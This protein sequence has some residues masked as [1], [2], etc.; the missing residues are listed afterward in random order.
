MNQKLTRRDFMSSAGWGLG[1]LCILSSARVARAYQAN[2]RL[3]LAVFGNMY[4]AQ[5]FLIAAHIYNAEVVAVCNPDQRKISDSRKLWQDQADKL[6]GAPTAEQRQ[7]A[8]RY[9]RMAQGEDVKVFADVRQVF[10]DMANQIDALVVS[11]YDH[12]HGVACGA[13]LRAG[14]PVCSERPLGLTISDARRLRAL[15][16]EAKLP[17]TYRSPGTGTG[18]FRRAIELVEDGL[19]GSV[20]E[21]HIWFKRGGPDRDGPPQGQEPVPDGLNWD[22][23]LGPLA[24]HEYHSD[25]MSYAHWRETSNGG[26]GS[27]GPHTTIFPFLTLGLR[28]LWDAPGTP[29]RVTAECARLNRISFP[30]WERVRWEI[31]AR[32]K[33]NMPPVTITWHHGPEFAPR[34]RELTHERMRRFGVSKPEEAD[35][36]MGN[37]G[38]MLIGSEGALVADDHSVRVTG[39]P[40]EKFELIETT[41]PHRI[42]ESFGIYKDWMDSCRGVER[43]I[44]ASFDNGGPLSEL[45]MLGNIATQYPGE[46]LSYDPVAGQIT[47]HTEANQKLVFKYRA[48]WRI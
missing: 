17:T 30:R 19:I 8:E 28:E 10:D 48:G 35:A 32:P 37:A 25:W 40:K 21:V 13:A 14:K 41:R 43:Q 3:R 31:P 18:P 4:N 7:V 38:S 12:F 26:L 29:I 5:H 45:L 16:A 34:A 27:F 6:A 15:A 20:Q 24:W 22:L 42:G 9:R 33:K 36:L 1:G 23:W 47:S 11:D 39:L 44:L 2:E 46:T